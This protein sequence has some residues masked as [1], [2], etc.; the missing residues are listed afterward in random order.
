[1][2]I[3]PDGQD[4]RLDVVGWEE[5]EAGSTVAAGAVC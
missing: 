4:R 1:M 3:G 5:R 2:R